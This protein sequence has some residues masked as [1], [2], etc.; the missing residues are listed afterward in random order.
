MIFWYLFDARDE[1]GAAL[2]DDRSALEEF[3]FDNEELS[4]LEELLGGFNIFD[5]VGIADA[6]IRHSNFLRWLLDPSENHGLG[7][8][9]LKPVLMDMLR[10][11]PADRRAVNL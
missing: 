2:Q 1:V 9:F 7:S 4:K 6:E 10:H 11:V 8:L 5:A 3:V